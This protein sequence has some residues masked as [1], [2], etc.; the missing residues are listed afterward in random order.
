MIFPLTL[1]PVSFGLHARYKKIKT[2]FSKYQQTFV[3]LN[4]VAE[5]NPNLLAL[6]KKAGQ[7]TSKLGILVRKCCPTSWTVPFSSATGDLAGASQGPSEQEVQGIPPPPPTYFSRNRS[8]TFS[9]KRPLIPTY[10]PPPRFSDLPTA[11]Q[12]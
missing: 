4:F 3:F 7:Y 1:T 10:P 6:L 11:L 2:G 9:S 12:P 8:K 5:L